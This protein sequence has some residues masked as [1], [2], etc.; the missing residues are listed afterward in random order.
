MTAILG[1]QPEDSLSTRGIIGAASSS[2]SEARLAPGDPAAPHR[3]R[4]RLRAGGVLASLALLSAAPAS[5]QRVFVPDAPTET[6][7]RLT[8]SLSFGAE[9]DVEASFRRHAGSSLLTRELSAAWSFDPAPAWQVYVNAVLSRT[10]VLASGGG[11]APPSGEFA[12]EF[13]EAYLRAGRPEAGP[14]VQVGRQRFEDERQ[15]LYD[16]DLDAVRLRYARG[17][18]SVELSAGRNGLVRK[19]LLG[20]DDRDRIDTYVLHAIH[21]PSDAFAVEGYAIVRDDRAARGERRVFAGLR[22]RGEPVEDLDYWLELGYGGGGW[23]A[24]VGTTYEWQVGPR[25]SLTLGL[26]FGSRSFRQT[27]LQ[28]NEGDFGGATDFKYYGEILDPELS[29]LVIVTVGIGVRPS[30]AWSLDLVY[31][32]Y[33]QDRPSAALRDAAIDAAP[34]GRRRSL[35]SEVDLVLG[36]VEILGHVEVKAIAGYFFPG[37]AFSTRTGIWGV[38]VEAQYRF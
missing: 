28:G 38:G 1:R 9:A 23:G 25:P 11:E 12:F 3:R 17:P 7:Y 24:E 30:E 21:E 29:N 2:P 26:A 13:K 14:A 4:R 8:P 15:W 31:H 27:G 32:H 36:A 10:F 33:R 35:G 5:A 34:S 22:S 19:N 18:F 16:E 37:A 6:P 20:P